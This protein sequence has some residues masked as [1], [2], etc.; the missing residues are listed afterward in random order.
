[1]VCVANP[2]KQRTATTVA[3][4]RVVFTSTLLA[5][6]KALLAGERPLDVPTQGRPLATGAPI[7]TRVGDLDA[8]AIEAEPIVKV[9]IGNQRCACFSSCPKLPRFCSEKTKVGSSYNHDGISIVQTLLGKRKQL[10]RCAEHPEGHRQ[11]TGCWLHRPPVYS[12]MQIR[13]L[14]VRMYMRPLA[15]AGVASVFS[16][17]VL[18]ASS[19]YSGPASSTITSPPRVTT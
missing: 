11:S 13:W 10:H 17:N 12:P 14:R 1:M 2:T 19:L 5:I 8:I 18:L 4:Q 9:P 15:I 7:R 3:E 6:G 16:G